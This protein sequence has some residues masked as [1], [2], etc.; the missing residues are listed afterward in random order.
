MWFGDLV[1]MR[2][3]DDVWM[4]EVL[5]SF[6]AAKIINPSF[7][8]VDHDL[9]FLLSNYPAAYQV[10]RAAGTNPIRQPLANLDEAGQLYG[11]IIY[12][13]APIAMRQLEMIA[14]ETAF[15]DGLREYLD[16]YRFGNAAWVDPGPRAR[17][18]HAGR[19]VGVEPCMGGGAGSAGV[20]DGAGGR[21]RPRLAPHAHR[22]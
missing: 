19:F 4:K 9:R 8:E 7:P 16:T 13:K 11:A 22:D 15:R 10:D 1:T 14:G 2:W 20:H 6:M 18:A 21:E 17:Y 12:Q 3:F 5:A